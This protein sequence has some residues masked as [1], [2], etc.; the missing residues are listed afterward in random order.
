MG[1]SQ[2]FIEV[3]EFNQFYELIE[4]NRKRLLDYFPNTAREISSPEKAKDHLEKCLVK[5]ELKEQFLFGIY[6]SKHLI[7]YLNVKN[8]D[9]DVPKCE[10]GYFIDFH[11]QGKGIMTAQI[12]HALL[13]SFENLEM[14]KIYLRIGQENIGSLKIAKRTGFKKEGLIR[15][16]FRT[17]TGELIDVAYY[18]ITKED[19]EKG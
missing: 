7:G 18:G 1:V 5:R 3:N 16:D 14:E 6:H 17:A 8:I 4:N 15:N 10:L 2:K 9:W 12:R 19:F 13:F 11:Q